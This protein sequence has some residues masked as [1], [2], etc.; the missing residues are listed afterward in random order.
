MPQAEGSFAIGVLSLF[1]PEKAHTVVMADSVKERG[2]IVDLVLTV[3][4][5]GQESQDAKAVI[6]ALFFDF[7]W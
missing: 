1:N 7:S 2:H 5:L 6:G 3:E 4:T